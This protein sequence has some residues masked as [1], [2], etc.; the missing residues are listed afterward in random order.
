MT[1]TDEDVLDLLN[2]CSEMQALI[3]ESIRGD[4]DEGPAEILLGS[5]NG[6]PD[7]TAL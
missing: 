3:V 4:H 5:I 1:G 6:R 2:F 7:A